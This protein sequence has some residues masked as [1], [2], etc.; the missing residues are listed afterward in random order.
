[1]IFSVPPPPPDELGP[2]DIEATSPDARHGNGSRGGSNWLDSRR[3]G[4]GSSRLPLHLAEA[5]LVSDDTE[6]PAGG[7]LRFRISDGDAAGGRRRS[8]WRQ[9]DLGRQLAGS[10]GQLRLVRNHLQDR[11]GTRRTLTAMLTL[12][13]IT[14]AVTLTR[15]NIVG[16]FPSIAGREPG[17]V[18]AVRVDVRFPAGL[19]DLA[20]P[21]HTRCQV[22]LEGLVRLL[23]VWPAPR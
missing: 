21:E 19:W 20:V 10:G 16:P 12:N 11:T 8:W 13:G 2:P 22:H 14:G 18:A 4:Q 17:Q 6:E 5:F 1:M 7:L 9:A 3:R 15:L 23:P